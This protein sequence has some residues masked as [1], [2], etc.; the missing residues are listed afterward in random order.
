MR[1]GGKEKG[2]KSDEVPNKLAK[3]KVDSFASSTT[4]LA[5][6]RIDGSARAPRT[7][8]MHGLDARLLW[9]CCPNTWFGAVTQ[10]HTRIYKAQVFAVSS[11]FITNNLFY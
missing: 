3:R 1:C 9:I 11:L 10:L 2:G 6:L 4:T 7:G 5:A 8:N